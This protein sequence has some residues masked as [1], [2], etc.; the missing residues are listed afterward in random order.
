MNDA[1]PCGHCIFR[2]PLGYTRDCLQ[3]PNMDTCPS[4]EMASF[5]DDIQRVEGLIEDREYED[6]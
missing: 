5:L 6:E 2:A 4:K 3:Y 1:A